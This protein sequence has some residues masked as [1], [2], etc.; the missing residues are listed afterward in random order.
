MAITVSQIIFALLF[1]ENW[2]F[3]SE[4]R[5]SEQPCANT[6]VYSDDII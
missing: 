5:Y 4:L 3:I 6:V 1:D 2:K